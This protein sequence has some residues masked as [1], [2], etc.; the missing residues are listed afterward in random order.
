MRIFSIYSYPC[1]K[2]LVEDIHTLIHCIALFPY[3]I[4][5]KVHHMIL[6]PPSYI[7]E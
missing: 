3:D 4:R 2:T 5:S 7:T 1:L 6:T